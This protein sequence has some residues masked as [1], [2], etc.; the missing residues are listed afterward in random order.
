MI[1]FNKDLTIND[2]CDLLENDDINRNSYLTSFLKILDSNGYNRIVS[3]NGRWGTGKTIFVQKFIC[4]V[5]YC[6]TYDKL[7]VSRTCIFKPFNDS[8]IVARLYNISQNKE[9]QEFDNICKSKLINAVY[10]NAW[11]H[12][13]ECDPIISIIYSLINEFNLLEDTKYTDGDF[14]DSVSN[15]VSLLSRGKVNLSIESNSFDL[16]SEVKLK[17]RI[18]DL[19]NNT[20]DSI[21][22]ENCNKLILFIDELDRCNPVYA[23]RLLERIKHYFNDD[24]IEVVISTNLEELSNTVSAMYGNNFSSYKYLDKFFDVKFELPIVDSDKYINTFDLSIIEDKNLFLYHTVQAVISSKKFEMRELY[25]YLSIIKIFE[26]KI[27]ENRNGRFYSVFDINSYIMIPL[28]IGLF[29][30]NISDYNAFIKGEKPDELVSFSKSNKVVM[31][32]IKYAIYPSKYKYNEE[33]SEEI[34]ID[35]ISKYYKF[36]YG[37]GFNNI[38][39]TKIEIGEIELFRNHIKKL[40]NSISLLEDLNLF[41]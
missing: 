33:V 32:I 26:P 3:L 4:L 35:A 27:F 29:V 7:N 5:N 13:D 9:F 20:L 14:L 6:S 38:N 40:R 1:N 18:R 10:F 30:D 15:L 39:S 41:F 36:V 25:R 2:I 37:D 23:V 16:L 31:E 17:D 21:I 19:L 12:D 8:D 34:L 11:E 22:C 28:I 24:R